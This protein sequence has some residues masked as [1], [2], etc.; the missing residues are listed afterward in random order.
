MILTGPV[1]PTDPVASADSTTPAASATPAGSATAAGSAASAGSV[2]PADSTAPIGSIG[3]TGSTVSAGSTGS[4]VP[5]GSTVP[6]GSAPPAPA[7][8]TERPAKPAWRSCHDPAYPRLQCASVKVP[9]DYANPGGRM[10]TIA[11][12]RVPAARG[13]RKG[14]LAVNPGGPGASGIALAGD[15]AAR[16]PGKFSREVIGFD[17]RGV[18]K[19][20]PALHCDVRYFDPIRPRYEP[21]TADQEQRWV[22]RVRGYAA[23]C[24]RRYGWLLPH[25]TTANAARDLDR[26][27]AALRQPKISFLGYSYGTY[28]GAVYGHMFP[29]RVERLV[30][31]SV[32]APSRVWYQANIRQ[33]YAFDARLRD[34]FGWVARHRERYRLGESARAVRSRWFAMRRALA[35][36]P[37]AGRVGSSELD[38]TF[39]AAG[40]D[41]GTW[42][43][44][45][46]AFAKHARGSG[47]RG[48][49]SA[50]DNLGRV[51]AEGENG[52][53]AYV[54][55]GCRDA[56]WPTQWR[57]WHAD[58]VRVNASAPFLTWNNTWYN[59]P[60]AF[61]P[62]PAS[63]PVRID[64]R[65]LPPTLLIQSERDAAT[66]REG[67]Y[68][69]RRAAPAARLLL[70]AG[71]GDHGVSL[72]GN[73]CVDG[74][75]F[76]FLGEGRLPGEPSSRSRRRRAGTPTGQTAADRAG[77]PA[78]RLAP[79]TADETCA[80]PP[81]PRPSQ[82]D[83]KMTRAVSRCL[84]RL[85]YAGVV[86][87]GSCR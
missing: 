24:E 23:A 29:S 66:P 81:A 71:G 51:G 37:A 9:L 31:D 19:S 77:A 25:M 14:V 68:E 55:V 70:E 8:P 22:R 12:S 59:A 48:L 15:I 30:L 7:G 18:G 39:M 2:S 17:P 74:H 10:I 13:A 54:A 35:H 41:S 64:G 79:G 83:Q 32:V 86:P 1:P 65:R 46:A 60:C 33:N 61:W 6:A 80:A 85:P 76:R 82:G 44:L 43:V 67:A 57:R 62:V 28:L 84:G 72:S 58:A 34:F 11:L 53:A 27:R 73:R 87:Q 3:S 45:A 40:Y 20:R 26:I 50:F 47:S 16:L 21:A 36:R 49:A 38:D 78:G 42:P 56:P 52:Y 69:L 4:T 63:Q 5:D 75:L